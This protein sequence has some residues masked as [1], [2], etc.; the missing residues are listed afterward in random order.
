MD[1]R[2]MALAAVI[3]SSIAI[4]LLLVFIAISFYTPPP[5]QQKYIVVIPITNVIDDCWVNP[6]LPYILNLN[7]SSVAGIIL[8]VDSPGGTLDATEALYGA[9]K[10]LGKPIY[11]VADGLDASGAFYVSMAAQRVYASPSA[12]VGNIGAWT[13]IEPDVFWTPI[14]LEV[15]STGPDKLYGMSLLQY[16]DSVDQAAASF[17]NVVVRSRGDRLKAPLSLLASGR[18]FTAQEALRLGLIDQIGGLSQAIADMARAL[19]L[20]KYSVVTIYSYFGVMPP[21]CTSSLSAEARIPLTFLLNTS[22]TP[23]YYIY[24]QAVEVD[25]NMS[26]SPPKVP[27]GAPPNTKYVVI[28]VSHGNF[29][30]QAFIQELAADLAQDNCSVAFALSSS[31]LT[32]LLGNAS[33]V[34]IAEPSVPYSQ[35][36]VDALASASRHGVRIAIF[37]DPRLATSLLIS[38]S[39]PEPVYLDALLSKFGVGLYDGYLYNGSALLG[40]FSSNWQFVHISTYNSTLVDGPLVFFT[41][42]ALA[43][44]G[45][46]AYAD[47][48]LTGYGKG[49]YAVVL[50]R[51]NVTVVGSITS[52]LPYFATLGNNAEFLANVA[53]W[54]CGG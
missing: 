37:Y 17:L 1:S 15:Y 32:N 49:V 23:I 52:F 38:S 47:A 34:V 50:Q 29:I 20:T 4:A 54:L 28:D 30:P 3:L 14:P 35:A 25:I 42:A 27:Q 51:G 31:E 53:N 45:A 44:S 12:L 33:G 41:P 6:L 16:Y 13:I 10:G 48:D 39:P 46:G 43:G 40:S 2:D 11:A 9:L 22:L 26:V 8:Y 36:A 5:P 7:K 18:L 24:P 21:N 19:N